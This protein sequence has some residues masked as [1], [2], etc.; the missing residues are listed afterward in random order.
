VIEE[1]DRVT[2]PDGLVAVMDLAR[3]RTSS[4]TES[5]VNLIGSDYHGR[6]LSAFY[7]DFYNS[8]YAAWTTE[9]LSTALPR[10]SDRNWYQLAP[11]GLPT[12]QFLLGVPATQ[13][14]LFL[15][16]GVPWSAASHPLIKEL[17]M[18]WHA[19]RQTLRLS[20]PTR[21]YASQSKVAR[22]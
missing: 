1:A 5:Y 18:D 2:N 20:K 11:I 21:L 22:C 14:K 10:Q 4:L 16:A 7:D 9:E 6:G 12:I 3:L 15:R 13:N 8:M 19:M 17:H